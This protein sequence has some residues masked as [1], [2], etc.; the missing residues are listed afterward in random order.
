VGDGSAPEILRVNT[1]GILGGG[2][3]GCKWQFAP[4]DFGSR[5][6]TLTGTI[7]GIPET[8]PG[9]NVSQRI[10]VVKFGI[11]WRFNWGKTLAPV[12]AKY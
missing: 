7:G 11:N 3:I 8:V 4:Y 5:T 2:Q 6:L 9:I 12:V 10:S 1:S